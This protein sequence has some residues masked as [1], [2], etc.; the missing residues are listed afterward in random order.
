MASM[1]KVGANVR[2]GRT[3]FSKA[4]NR[5]LLQGA[6]SK[7]RERL[8]WPLALRMNEAFVGVTAHFPATECF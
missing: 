3:V 8:G 1:L 5:C 2:A 7:A 4:V 6:I